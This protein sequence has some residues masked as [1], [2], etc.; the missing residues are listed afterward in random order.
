MDDA[1]LTFEGTVL[2][3][4]QLPPDMGYSLGIHRGDTS[5][6]IG[7]DEHDLAAGETCLLLVIRM[8]K[9]VVTDAEPL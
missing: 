2:H 7:E 9:E 5:I 4:E 8:K 1:K 6:E 3:A